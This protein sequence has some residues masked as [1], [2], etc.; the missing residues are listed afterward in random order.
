MDARKPVKLTRQD[1]KLFAQEVK[2]WQ[3]LLGVTDWEINIEFDEKEDHLND[4][5]PREA[6]CGYNI[7]SR[8][9]TIA[10]MK[11]QKVEL[12]R[13]AIKK[14]AFHE[15]MHLVMGDLDLMALASCNSQDVDGEVHKVI[16]RMTNLLFEE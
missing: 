12:S 16:A 1:F 9:A 10:L 13:Q 5:Q 11:Y 6:W 4:T 3:K 14:S 2:R 15:V 8:R 7:T